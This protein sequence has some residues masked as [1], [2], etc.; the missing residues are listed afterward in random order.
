MTSEREAVQEIIAEE[1]LW[2]NGSVI[3]YHVTLAKNV[4]KIEREG[5]SPA[6]STGRLDASWYVNKAGV[7][8]AIAHC[9]QRH[10]VPVSDLFV[11]TVMLPRKA[12]KRTAFPQMFYVRETYHVAAVT[13]AYYFVTLGDVVNE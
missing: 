5:V 6:Y 7:T 11:C 1:V 8:W 13:Q 4:G 9:S 12:I 10:A 3:A 2:S